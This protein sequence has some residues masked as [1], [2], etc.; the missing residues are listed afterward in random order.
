MFVH[1]SDPLAP[2]GGQETPE[3]VFLNRRSWLRL[4]AYGGAAIVGGAGYAMWRRSANGQDDEVIA[5]GRWSPESE[6]KYASFYPARRDERFTYGRAETIAAEA[7]R[8]TNFYEFSRF[9][10]CWKYVQRFQPEAWTITIGGLCRNP[11][12]LDLD[13]FHKLFQS[14]LVERQYRHRCVERWAMAIP[15][16]GIPL[17][18]LVKAADP[19]AQATHVRLVS[20]QRP[21]EAPHQAEG[22]EFPWP[23]TEGLTLAEATNELPLLAVGV[24]GR[25]LL[26]QHGAPLRLVVPWKYGYK[27]IKSVEF[28]EFVG[29]EPATFWNT[30]NPAAYPFESNVDPAVHRPWNQAYE[31]M[32]GTGERRP[33][34]KF[35]GYGQWVAGLYQSSDA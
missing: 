9:K 7:A 28:I 27:S 21:S 18:A 19:L 2:R 16:T 8:Y 4:A 22:G 30:M 12:T 11:L 24:Y 35:N 26:K 15:W 29:R 32:L 10:W 5:A 23:Y 14:E 31:T 34:E 6:Q 13:A 1:H 3:R 25:P 20:F 17:A 33:T